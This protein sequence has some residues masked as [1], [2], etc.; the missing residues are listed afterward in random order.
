MGDYVDYARLLGEVDAECA[1]EEGVA[2]FRIFLD[3]W[4]AFREALWGTF[5]TMWKELVPPGVEDPRWCAQMTGYNTS[6]M[7]AYRR[8]SSSFE[9]VGLDLTWKSPRDFRSS[10]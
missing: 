2:R 9:V 6:S 8:H 5:T 3:G 7:Q 4:P 1:A 10:R